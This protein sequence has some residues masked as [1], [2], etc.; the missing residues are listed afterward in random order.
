M[1]KAPK[2][3]L[4]FYQGDM[5]IT[6][7]QGDQHRAI[8]RNAEQPL[9]EVNTEGTHTSGLLATDDKGSVLVVQEASEQ[10]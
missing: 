3:S 2:R 1:S 6:V 4:Y 10:P 8:F 5:L 9:A 7:K